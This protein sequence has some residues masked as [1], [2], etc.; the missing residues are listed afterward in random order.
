MEVQLG[1]RRHGAND[2]SRDQESGP[3]VDFPRTDS[4]V[5][6]SKILH[7]ADGTYAIAW[8]YEEPRKN[9]PGASFRT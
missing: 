8:P 6:S 5:K 7:M 9:K 4:E 3:S 1:A 2:L